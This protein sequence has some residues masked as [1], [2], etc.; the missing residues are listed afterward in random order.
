MEYGRLLFARS[1]LPLV[2]G[3]NG[4]PL[5]FTLPVSIMLVSSEVIWMSYFHMGY[6]R[7]CML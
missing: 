6:S 4:L 3:I 7:S 5:N 1:L 2:N